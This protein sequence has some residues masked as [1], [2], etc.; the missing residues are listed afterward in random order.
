MTLIGILGAKRFASKVRRRSIATRERELEVEKKLLIIHL[1]INR[2]K[3]LN[4]EIKQYR[5]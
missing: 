1:S 5:A 2:C 4:R 3:I